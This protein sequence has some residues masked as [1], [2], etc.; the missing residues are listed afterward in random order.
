M[1]P[2]RPRVLVC[3][4]M[5]GGYGADAALQGSAD[6]GAFRL[7]H[8]HAVDIFVYFSHHLVTLPPPGWVHAAHRHG[9][10][11]RP[12]T[13]PM[14]RPLFAAAPYH[15]KPKV[16]EYDVLLAACGLAL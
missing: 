3:H 9:V 2:Q 6:S 10:Q 14:A 11:V 8:W 12:L 5:A 16:L 15:L 7:L 1:L 13:A 4:D